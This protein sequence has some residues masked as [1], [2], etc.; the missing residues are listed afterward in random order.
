MNWKQHVE[1]KQDAAQY[2]Q[3]WS[4]GKPL[5]PV[6]NVT[7]FLLLLLNFLTFDL[8]FLPEC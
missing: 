5:L 8:V 1:R 2:T 4:D 7:H 6:F 3:T